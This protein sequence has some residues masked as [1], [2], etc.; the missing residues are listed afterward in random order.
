MLRTCR[1]INVAATPATTT[2]RLTT[3][4]REA[5]DA[6]GSTSGRY[7]FHA[8]IEEADRIEE[9][10]DDMTAAAT[11]PSPSV[12]TAG[13]VRWR[14]TYGRA[15][16]ASGGGSPRADQ[17]T[18]PARTPISAGGTAASRQHTAASSDSARA[19]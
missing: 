11:A 14:S 9:S 7:R 18:A 15:S 6:P 19:V 16:A 8:A 4:V 12:A 1:A 17:S 10:T 5:E 2:M 3:R 13:G